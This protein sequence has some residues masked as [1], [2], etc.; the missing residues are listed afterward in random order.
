MADI[1]DSF[2]EIAGVL[3][4]MLGL[5][6]HSRLRDQIRGTVDLYD[7]IAVHTELSKSKEDLQKVIEYQTSR[8]LEAA[9]SG[10]RKYNWA[11]LVVCWVISFLAGYGSY[12]IWSTLPYWW[13]YLIFAVVVLVG[14]LFF[15]AGI[16]TFL[17]QQNEEA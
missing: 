9:S 10:K 7:S 1:S 5:T 11:A 13:G 8:L 2:G 15:V 16:G 4:T 17:Q 3:R 6:R 14:V 12:Q